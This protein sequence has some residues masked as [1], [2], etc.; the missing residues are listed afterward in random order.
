LYNSYQHGQPPTDGLKEAL[1]S[2]LAAFGQSYV[3]VDAL[4]ECPSGDG[5]RTTLTALLTE[6]SKWSLPNLH[7]LVTSRKEPDID[8]ALA[9]LL[10]NPPICIQSKQVDADIKVHVRTQ[11]A[12]DLNLKK[13][14]PQ[15]KED[16]ETSLVNGANGMWESPR[17]ICSACRALTS[18]AAFQVSMG[19]LPIGEPQAMLE[20]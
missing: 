7:I 16:I 17:H 20:T 15:I 12:I 14:S 8:E 19:V 11:L 4:D 13:W 1:R 3:I 5:E 10:T 9:P 2:M 6:F 18:H